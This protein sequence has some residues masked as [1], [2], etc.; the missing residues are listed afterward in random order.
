ME[1][2]PPGPGPEGP[3]YGER[4]AAAWASYTAGQF[5][6]A[7]SGFAAAVAVNA[8][9]A[10]A[11]VGLGWSELRMD[12]PDA[13]HLAFQDGSGRT[14][15]DPVMADLHAGWAF[16]WNARQAA[17]GR[18]AESNAAVAQ[19]LALEPAWIFDH[20]AGLDAADLTL[21]AAGNFFALGD[22]A[23]SLARVQVLDPAFAADVGT[24][25]GRAALAARIEALRTGS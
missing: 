2:D 16:G 23:S 17:A 8:A 5:A 24:A 18:H 12:A 3:T 20:E 7:R 21:L 1:P 14:G 6:A 13:A 10:D 9:R 4:V 11:Y 22:F 19:A 15:S 25:T